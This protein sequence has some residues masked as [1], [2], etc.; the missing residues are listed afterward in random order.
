MSKAFARHSAVVMFQRA[1]SPPLF[2]LA[3]SVPAVQQVRLSG[4]SLVNACL[5]DLADTSCRYGAVEDSFIPTDRE[6]GGCSVVAYLLV[7]SSDL[8]GCRCQAALV[9]SAS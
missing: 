8:F 4:V 3:G 6:T 9:A 5:D 7:A 1:F 2:A